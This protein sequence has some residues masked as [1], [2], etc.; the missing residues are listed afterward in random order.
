MKSIMLML[1][2]GLAVLYTQAQNPSRPFITEWE[3][4]GANESITIPTA[5]EGHSYM[6]NWGDGTTDNTIYT[7]DA[8]HEYADAGTYTVIISGAFPRIRFASNAVAAGQ[9]RTVKQWGDMAWTSMGGAF[10]GCND[11]TIADDAGIPDLS[12]IASMDNMFRGS[13][14]TGD[15]SGWNVSGVTSMKRMFRESSFNGDLGKWDVSSVNNMEEIFFNSSMSAENYDALLIGWSTLDEV[16]GET[17]IPTDIAFGAPVNYTC[18]SAMARD[19]LINDYSWT[20]TGDN[21]LN[22]TT[23]PVPSVESLGV[24]TGQ[25]EVTESDLTFPTATDNCSGAVTVTHDVSSFPIAESTTITWT[26]RDESGNEATQTQEVTIADTTNPVPSVESLGV[27]TG[28]CEV[29][30]GDLPFPTATD[31][32]SGAVTVTHDVINFPITESTTITWTYRDESGNEATQTQE[33]TIADTTNPVPSVESLG[34]VT[35]QCEV[36]ESDLTFPTATDNCSGAVTVT[37]DVSNFPITEST[38][39]TW[40][41]RDESGNEATQTQ[42]VTITPCA[43]NPLGAADPVVEA[44]VFPNPSDRYIEVTSPVESPVSIL[45]LNGNLLQESTT[46][47]KMDIAALRSGL[48]LVRLSDGRLLKFIKK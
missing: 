33:V 30:A 2:A 34:V 32:C 28:Q 24:V 29:T 47:T 25:C 8:S 11:L 36:T 14:L 35:G 39:I 37:H 22:D 44:A 20:I 10:Q 48:Y 1:L 4:T 13:S 26:Y 19:R 27:V 7:G 21:M 5:W 9:I 23:N 17:Q 31:N 15:L 46:N 16:S 42:E 3:T 6:V 45:D 41:Y 18:L 43:E 38:T 12:G 40:T